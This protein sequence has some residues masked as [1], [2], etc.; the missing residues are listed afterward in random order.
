MTNPRAVL[1]LA[2]ILG[3]VFGLSGTLVAQ[4]SSNEEVLF[5]DARPDQT[6]TVNG[7]TVI[8]P[9]QSQLWRFWFQDVYHARVS[10]DGTKVAYRFQNSIN[11]VGIDGQNP[12]TIAL[13]APG[14]PLSWSPSGDRLAFFRGE[15]PSELV[16]MA[17]D[18]TVLAVHSLDSDGFDANRQPP[19]WSPDGT[20]I[21]GTCRS[22]D[23]SNRSWTICTI[24]VSTGVQTKLYE[25]LNSTTFEDDC[26][27]S[28]TERLTEPA[29]SPAGDRIAAIRRTSYL[30]SPAG[31]FLECDR[32]ARISM[33][34][35]TLPAS[36]GTPTEVSS[37]Y[38]WSSFEDPGL[39]YALT[40]SPDATELAYSVLAAGTDPSIPFGIYRV[41]ATGG[42]PSLFSGFVTGTTQSGQTGIIG[43]RALQWTILKPPDGL[44]VNDPGDEQDADPN[45]G[46]LDT[47]LSAGGLQITLRAAIEAANAA[48]GADTITFNIPG[49]GTPVITPQTPLPAIDSRVM[50]DGSSQPGTGLVCLSGAAAPGDGLCITDGAVELKGL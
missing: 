15:F 26:R 19:S 48:V 36:G 7:G 31:A 13:N 29:W 25:T 16:I 30:R 39:F 42:T 44:E 43:S 1:V 32:E 11:I 3:A 34:I 20:M 47:D 8:L 18:G 2:S 10:P 50:I 14:F 24:D 12:Q 27:I 22:V 45:D 17:L 37:P 28:E 35:V 4:Q 38:V 40:W 33:G 6:G 23:G 5:F 9:M 49:A 41:P 46:V 21:A